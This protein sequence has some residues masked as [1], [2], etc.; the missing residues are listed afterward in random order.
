M[1]C[2]M[3]VGRTLDRHV[4]IDWSLSSRDEERAPFHYARILFPISAIQL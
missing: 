4:Q 3:V 2:A 1:E